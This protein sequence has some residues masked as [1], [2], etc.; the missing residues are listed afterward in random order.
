VMAVLQVE[1][2]SGSIEIVV[3]PDLYESVRDSIT[4]EAVLVVQA[5]V[6]ERNEELQLVAQA[7]ADPRELL[8]ELTRSSRVVHVRLPVSDNV[9]DDIEQMHELRELFSQFPGD[10][11]VVLHLPVGDREIVLRARLHV[12]WCED[13][14]RVVTSVLAGKGAV[15]VEE[16]RLETLLDAA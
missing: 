5:R 14:V 9:D 2:R 11:E 4:E 13:F 6:E 10:D 12:D 8:R 1:D 7:I 3:F 16:H 15:W